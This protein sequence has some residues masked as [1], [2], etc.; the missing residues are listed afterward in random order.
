[1]TSVSGVEIRII[2]DPIAA[3]TA[4]RTGQVDIL[5]RLNPQHVPILQRAKGLRVV[6]APSRMP[7]CA[8]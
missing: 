2:K 3:I 1:M 6:T 5:Q 8:T 4:L 7:S